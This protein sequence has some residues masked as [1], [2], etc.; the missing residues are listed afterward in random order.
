MMGNQIL[1]TDIRKP[2]QEAGF[3]L[4]EMLIGMA[5]GL[6]LLAGLTMLFVS[7][8]D[9]SR[10]V[11]LRTERMGD[12]FLTSQ[13][14]QSELRQSL[15]APLATTTLVAADGV[16]ADLTARGVSMT[17]YSYPSTEATFA[18]L[19]YWDA[20]SK[21]ITYQD[22]DGNVGIFHYQRNNNDRLY[23]LRPDASV[24]QFAELIRDLNTATGLTVTA[25]GGVM[26]IKL[27]STYTNENKE[28]K[29]LDITFKTRPRN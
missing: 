25:P 19:P 3:T 12:L 5:M 6:I 17:G 13:V 28:S 9:S 15:N 4:I 1:P 10:A 29:E 16:L 27:S 22:L 14:M 18:T 8:N 20:A 2:H 23:W 11:T 24:T 26:T 7:F 21:T